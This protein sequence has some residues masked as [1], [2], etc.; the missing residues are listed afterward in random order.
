M[1]VRNLARALLLQPARWPRAATAVITAVLLTALL[2]PAAAQA[3]PV[4]QHAA[5]APPVPVL[6]WRP[7]DGGF[8]CATAR[9][10][11]DYRRPRGATI[12]LAVLRHLAT[13]PAR[14][15]GSLFVN[16]GGPNEQIEGILRAYHNFPAALRARFDIITFDPR[17]F[18]YST[19]I[20]CFPSEAAEARLLSGLPPFPVGAKQE[21][22]WIRT[23]TRFDALCARRNGPLLEHDTTADVARD[24]NLLRQ[25]VHDPVLNYLG[26]SYGSGLGATYAN[27]FPARVGRMILDGNVNPVSWTHPDGI[28][29][30]FLRLGSGQAAAASMTAFLNL[31][32]AT[33]TAN[34]AFAAGSPAATRARWQM[35]LRRVRRHPVSIGSPP[36]RYT[37]ADVIASVPLGQV[38]AWPSGA[39]LL[40]HLWTASAP[41]GTSARGTVAH[42]TAAGRGR[43]ALA[44]SGTAGTSTPRAAAATP[45]YTGLEQNLAVLCSDSANPR[46]PGAY[47]AAARLAYRSSGGFGLEW[48]WTAEPC[49]G[50]PDG[51]APDRYAG[52]WNRPTA[53]TLLLLGNTGDPALPYQ[54]SVALAHDLARARL[55]TVAGYGHTEANNPSSC[56]LG[57]EISYLETGALPAPGT[58]CHEDTAPFAPAGS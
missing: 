55:L 32:G 44:A 39:A 12:R 35:L 49:A 53:N 31:C 50:W 5:T 57:Y 14:R 27:L 17:G 34:C 52:P 19:A 36:Q 25:A 6:R 45:P 40:E 42:S 43:A 23:Y 4:Q 18:G 3:A 13:E 9:V 15:I 1:S 2:A 7:C 46:D 47:Q 10:P 30:V 28:Q 38:S 16:G 48:A 58:V 11:L 54:D 37:Y 24:M 29:P 33:S 22:T 20:R 21:A 51:A 8:Q 56:A 26:L 41:G